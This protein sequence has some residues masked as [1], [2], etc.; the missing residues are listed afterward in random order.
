MILD[1][2][3]TKMMTDLFFLHKLHKTPICCELLSSDRL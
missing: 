1:V 2:F 3:S